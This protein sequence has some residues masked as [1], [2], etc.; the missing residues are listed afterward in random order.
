MVAQLA[1]LII[2]L[3]LLAVLLWILLVS[4]SIQGAVAAGL[5]ATLLAYHWIKVRRR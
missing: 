5:I 4:P 3:L 2:G 1:V